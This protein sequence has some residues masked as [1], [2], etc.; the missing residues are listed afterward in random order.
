MI[1]RLRMAMTALIPLSFFAAATAAP[2]P[3]TPSIDRPTNVLF[4]AVDDLRPE[5][6]CYGH[7]RVKSPHIDRLAAGGLIFTR[8]YCQQAVCGQSRASLLTGLRPDTL[9]GSGMSVHFRKYVPDVV[10]LPQNF[11]QHGYHCEAMGKIFHGAFATAYVGDRMNDPPSWS[12]PTFKPGPRY[13][14]TPEGVAIA[15]KLFPL[16]V[17][18]PPTDPDDWTKHFVRGLATEAPEIADNVPYD[19]QIADRAVE[20]LGQIKDR[21]FF[22]AVGFLKPHLPF[23]A[24][25]KYWDLYDAEE[26]DL[27]DNP[28]PPEGVPP[29]AMTSFAELRYYHDAPKKG[30]VSDEM[31]R[32]LIHGYY[33]CVSYVDAQIGRVLDELER[34]GLRDNT[35]VILWGDHGWHLGDHGLWCKHTNFENA[36]RVPLMI[37]APG[38]KAAGKKSDGL[39]ELVDI[40]PTLCELAGVPMPDNLEGVSFAP[41]LNRSELPWKRAAF[42]QYP[43]GGVM[44]YSMRTGRYRFTSWQDREAPHVRRAVELYDHVRD[45]DENVNL[46][47]RPENA[48]LVEQLSEQLEAG[49][50]AAAP[51]HDSTR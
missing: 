23:V 11:K 39:V 35:I 41:L 12:V 43:R 2:Q 18:D 10:T 4:I 30:P 24:P 15:E 29:M 46:A 36:T 7:P 8:A 40:Y 21:P 5:L 47:D 14:Y 31:A 26:I 33:A 20:R 44:G 25:K 28:F 50:P 9:H 34:L 13:Y 38:M 49:W 48:Q 32:R 45:P 6:G 37:S 3:N 1:L 19:G 42:S 51:S 22:L 17:K 27:A 16:Q